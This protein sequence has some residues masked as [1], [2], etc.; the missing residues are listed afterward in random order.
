VQKFRLLFTSALIYLV[1]APY[2]ANNVCAQE[3]QTY[4]PIEQGDRLWTIGGKVS[5]TSVSRHQAILALLRANPHAFRTSCNMNS[6]LKLDEY[7][8]VPSSLEMQAINRTEAFEEFKRQEEEWKNRRQ[9]PI[10]CPEI[11]QPEEDA[12]PST[13][14]I[15]TEEV[16]PVPNEIT[17]TPTEELIPPTLKPTAASDLHAIAVEQNTAGDTVRVARVSDNTTDDNT[18][19]ASHS[20]LS[21]TLPMIIAILIAMVL[22]VIVLTVLLHKRAKNKAEENGTA[23]E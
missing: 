5:P 12:K 8:N 23:D 6:S 7:L 4:G 15:T 2:I 9:N 18:Q 3:G 1:L 19:N 22:F 20:S 21:L 17:E 11:T 13:A 16:K 14:E 10:V